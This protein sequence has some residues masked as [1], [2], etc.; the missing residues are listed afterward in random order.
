MDLTPNREKTGPARLLDM[1]HGGSKQAFKTWLSARP[2]AWRDALTVVAMDGFAGFKTAAAE[3]APDAVAV[4]DP[5]HVVRLAGDA[6]DDCRRRV[7]QHIHGHRG[8]EGDPLYGA[9]RTLHT[10]MCFL[11]EW[12]GERLDALFA[13]ERHSAVEVTWEFYQRLV[14]AY[15]DPDRAKGKQLMQALIDAIGSRVPQA[16]T[17]IGKLGQTLTRRA[18][19]V[20]AYFERPDRGDQ[21]PPRAPPRLR[22]RLPQPHQLHRPI[23]PRN[24]RIQTTA[25]PSNAMSPIGSSQMRV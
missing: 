18:T 14:T 16:L 13:D 23:A 1:V 10:G 11:T 9:R 4:M 5:F 3:E 15:R 19:D 22:P 8:R 12:Q 21:Q 25:T 2:K 24:R 6:L 20:L 7:Q 17:E